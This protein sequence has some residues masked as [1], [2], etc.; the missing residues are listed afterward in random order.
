MNTH[1]RTKGK[2]YTKV[3]NVLR[4]KVLKQELKGLEKNMALML[5]NDITWFMDNRSTYLSLKNK[6]VTHRQK[7]ENLR[8]NLPEHGFA[9]GITH[10][11]NKHEELEAQE[12]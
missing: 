9:D 1:N 2:Y 12:I 3:E 7:I 11:V 4:I 8:I 10:T 5:K 6:I